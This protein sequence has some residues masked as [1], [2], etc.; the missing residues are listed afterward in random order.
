ML[1]IIR[2][3]KTPQPPSPLEKAASVCPGHVSVTMID[4]LLKLSTHIWA[5]AG[6]QPALGSDLGTPP[7]QA[8]MW[9]LLSLC[10]RDDTQDPAVP[11]SATA[12]VS[13]PQHEHEAAR[14]PAS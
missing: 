7:A 10:C 6:E 13:N 2:G 3:F 12:L 5:G 8:E 9:C 14:Q 11:S 4:G 1:R